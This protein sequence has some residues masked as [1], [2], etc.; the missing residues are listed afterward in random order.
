[1][2]KLLLLGALI[3]SIAM[4][5]VIEARLGVDLSNNGKVKYGNGD[6]TSGFEI[7]GEYRREVMENLEMGGGFSYNYSKLK[8]GDAPGITARGIH[9][10]PVYFTTR[11]KF[12]D[13]NGV[14]PYVK[15]N[16]GIAI[17]SGKLEQKDVFEVKYN[18]GFYYEAGAGIEYKNFVADLSYN[19]N[20]MGSKYTNKIPGTVNWNQK[21][22]SNAGAFTLG[23]GYS[24]KF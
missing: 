16:L 9:S 10:M 3:S 22:N 20:T 15:G 13:F 4:A 21:Y 6:F 2:K 8:A 7:G 24:F 11:Y 1:M 17:N 18:S 5:D 12:K 14:T 19:V 23:L